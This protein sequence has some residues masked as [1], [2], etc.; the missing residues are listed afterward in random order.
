LHG[1]GARTLVAPPHRF[2]IVGPGFVHFFAHGINL[3]CGQAGSIAP[4]ARDAGADRLECL[5]PH[6]QQR[7]VRL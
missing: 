1:T 6:A 7:A 3:H 5:T 2:G 4:F